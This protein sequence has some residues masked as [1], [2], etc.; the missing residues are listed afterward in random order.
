M[1]HL[2]R[3]PVGRRILVPLAVAA[4]TGLVVVAP[5]TAQNGKTPAAIA[6]DGERALMYTRDVV[7]IGPRP[8]GSEELERTRQYIEATL[9]GFGLS[10]TRD[11]LV[12]DTPIGGIPIANLIAEVPA[13]EGAPDGPVIILSGHYDTMIA[14][15]FEF[16]GANDGGSSTGIL[17]EMGRVLV[18]HPPPLPV[19]LV[20]FDGEEAVEN[21]SETDSRYGSHHMAARM[22]AAGELDRI[23]AM[24][25]MDMIGDADLSFPRDGNGTEW[26]NDI[27]WET[28]SELGYAEEFVPAPAIQFMEDDHLPFL[29]HGRNVVAIDLIDW[30]Y[31]PGNRYWH[32][33]FDTMDKLSA[34]SFQT[35]GEVVLTA[36]PR[37]AHHILSQ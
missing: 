23:G 21:W 19:W 22:E 27:V 8:I 34:S 35:I 28:A 25:L 10:V 16:V 3:T 7:A 32:S 18:E 20:F 36:L 15:G 29:R 33:P 14:D 1:P 30:S 31:G 9:D 6:F 2:S 13:V 24:I 4:L 17:L 11:E 12:A 26:L 5:G 37:V